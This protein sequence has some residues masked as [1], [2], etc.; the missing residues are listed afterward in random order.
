[1][2][3]LLQNLTKEEKKVCVYWEYQKQQNFAF[4]LCE[5]C[6][7]DEKEDKKHVSMFLAKG[8]YKL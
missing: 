5:W 6:I 4:R 3:V 8:S 7:I 1:M 2:K